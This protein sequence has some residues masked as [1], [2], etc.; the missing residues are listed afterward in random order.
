LK[1]IQQKIIVEGYSEDLKQTEQD[2]TSKLQ[3]REKQEEIYWK[4]KSRNKWL[5]EGDKN[6]KLFHQTTV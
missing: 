4:Q 3:Q 2:C 6:T 5:K 1:Y